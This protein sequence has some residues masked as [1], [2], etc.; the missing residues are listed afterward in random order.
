MVDKFNKTSAT[1]QV[2]AIYQGAYADIAQKLTAAT[3]AKTLPEVAQMGGAPYLADS[4][5]LVP[6]TELMSAADRADIYQAFWDYNAFKGQIVTMPFNNSVPM[7]FYNK[8]M[9]SAAGLDPNKPPGDL[10]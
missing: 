10:G 8:D 6:V 1:T 5:A 3:T 9:F 4:G 2:E 7:L